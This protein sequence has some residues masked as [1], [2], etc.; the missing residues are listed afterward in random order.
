MAAQDP[1]SEDLH[2]RHAAV[3]ELQSSLLTT[4]T[5]EDFL[6]RVVDGAAQH[7][8]PRMSCTLT[9]LRQNSFVTVASSDEH[10]TAADEVEYEVGSGPCVDAARDGVAHVIADLRTDD[11]W[12]TWQEASVRLGFLS[13]AAVPGDTGDGGAQISF[14]LYGN[15]AEA[16]GKP[17]LRRAL[18]YVDEVA[19]ALRLSLLLAQQ[20]T[21]AEDLETA[22]L[23]RSTIDQALGVIMGQNR[24][25]RDE[26]FEILRAASQSRNVKLRDVAALVIQS[27]TG[28]PPTDPPPFDR[29]HGSR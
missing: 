20:A 16:F 15:E 22:M 28:H 21:L 8:A 26:A 27:L 3:S 29:G 17:E 4:R 12:P 14:N 1:P 6:Q 10:A 18:V 19:R 25:T 2:L 5:V 24:T 9:M 13:A 23:S 11:R 7:V